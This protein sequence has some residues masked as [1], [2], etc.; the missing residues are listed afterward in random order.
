MIT[1]PTSSPA[2]SQ[3]SGE[4]STADWMTYESK[5]LGFEITYPPYMKIEKELSDEDNRFTSIKGNELDVEI[6]LR[7]S[8]DISF[9]KY[10]YMDNAITSQSTLG[11]EKANVYIQDVRQSGCVNSGEGPG[12]P[13]S[14]VSYAAV[15]GS[16]IYHLGF[17]GDAV[18]SDI[19]KQILSSF[20]FADKDM[21]TSNPVSGKIYGNTVVAFEPPLSS[22]DYAE[23]RNKLIENVVEPYVQYYDELEG[24]GF[25]VSLLLSLN[26][27]PNSKDYPYELIGIN[28]NG[29]QE[30]M[31]LSNTQYQDQ[32]WWTPTC[33][34]SCK[35]TESFRNKYPGIAKQVE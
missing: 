1:N 12:C 17:Y 13:V 29:G 11:G 23:A 14:F 10:Y 9:D 3:I 16:D 26:T 6:M 31:S 35:L 8:G 34:G 7:K 22:S 28:K 20:K 2:S 30:Y 18:L 32:L 25:V 21:T 4:N 33:Q 15:K 27:D 5:D 24:K 19:E